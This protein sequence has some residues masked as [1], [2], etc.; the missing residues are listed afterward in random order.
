LNKPPLKKHPL[1]P[2]RKPGFRAKLSGDN[3]FNQGV[4]LDE[5]RYDLQN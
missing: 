5:I 2:S 3:F 4:I 1:S